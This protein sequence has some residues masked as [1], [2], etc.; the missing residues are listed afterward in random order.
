MDVFSEGIQLDKHMLFPFFPVHEPRWS[1]TPHRSLT[2]W[3][4]AMLTLYFIK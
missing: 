4:W 1:Q 2:L 3:S